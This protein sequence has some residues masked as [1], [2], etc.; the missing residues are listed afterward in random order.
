MIS[1]RVEIKLDE[2]E[3][4]SP[5]SAA[6]KIKEDLVFALRCRAALIETNGDKAAALKLVGINA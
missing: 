3:F 2:R 5:Q 1:A 6:D 4:D